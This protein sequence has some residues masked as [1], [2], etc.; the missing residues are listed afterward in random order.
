MGDDKPSAVRTAWAVSIHA[1]TGKGAPFKVHRPT[2]RARAKGDQAPWPA[3][4][5]TNSSTTAGA[6]GRLDKGRKHTQLT[7]WRRY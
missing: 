1:T 2:T 3:P 7:I 6:H 5:P 4:R